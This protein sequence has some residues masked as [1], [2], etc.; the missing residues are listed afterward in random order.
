[1]AASS[2]QPTAH[3]GDRVRKPEPAKTT[4]VTN[5]IGI[6]FELAEG[7]VS[8]SGSLGAPQDLVPPVAPPKKRRGGKK[9]AI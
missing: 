7:E 2:P 3:P 9:A 6:S 8:I 5:S 1:M 4:T